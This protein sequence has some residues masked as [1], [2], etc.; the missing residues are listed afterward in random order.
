MLIIG[1]ISFQYKLKRPKTSQN[2]NFCSIKIAH[3]MTWGTSI[4]D[5]RYQSRQGGPRQPPKIEQSKVVKY[6][7]NGQKTWDVIHGCSIMYNDFDS[8]GCARPSTT[9]VV[10]VASAYLQ[11]LC[12]PEFMP[13]KR[14]EYHIGFIGLPRQ[15]TT[16]VYSRI[17]GF[18]A[19]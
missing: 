18:R 13:H 2:L 9:I 17:S 8:V 11:A 16:R 6:V 4:N 10:I 1:P 5:V 7:K 3:H 19:L 15:S 12:K 14:R